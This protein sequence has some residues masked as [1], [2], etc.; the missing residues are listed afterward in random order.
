MNEYLISLDISADE[1]LRYYKGQAVSVIARDQAGRRIR[2]PA[3]AL[4]P[5]VTQSGVHGRFRLVTDDKHRL[6]RLEKLG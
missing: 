3:T 6:E 1:Y 5:Y 2:F 4:R